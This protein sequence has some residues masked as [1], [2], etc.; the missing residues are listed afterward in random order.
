MGEESADEDSNQFGEQVISQLEIISKQEI[1]FRRELLYAAHH[2]G[3]EQ[4][5]L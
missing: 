1:R 5:L 2:G 3:L 4:S